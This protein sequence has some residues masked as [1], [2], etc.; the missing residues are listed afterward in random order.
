[1]KK[2]MLECFNI[3]ETY[4]FMFYDLKNHKKSR[5]PNVPGGTL[6]PQ[7]HLDPETFGPLDFSW[8]LR[9]SINFSL[10]FHKHNDVVHPNQV[11]NYNGNKTPLLA[12]AVQNTE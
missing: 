11:S 2:N 9:S 5:G 8:C 3:A 1:M 12:N 7:G 4:R 10:Y 6:G